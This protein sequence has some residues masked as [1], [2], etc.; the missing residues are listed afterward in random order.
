MLHLF[1]EGIIVMSGVKVTRIGFAGNIYFFYVH[2]F[3]QPTFLCFFEESKIP[4]TFALDISTFT[5]WISFCK[6]G[7]LSYYFSNYCV[8]N[9]F[10][11]FIEWSASKSDWPF[12]IWKPPLLRL[13]KSHTKIFFFC[14]ITGQR[15]NQHRYN[16]A[17]TSTSKIAPFPISLLVKWLWSVNKSIFLKISP[18]CSNVLLQHQKTIFS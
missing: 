17:E 1:F 7:V 3:T 15:W 8:I 10:S 16:K 11:V 13:C 9:K 12:W 14:S 6:A 5:Y 4:R 18:R 2:F